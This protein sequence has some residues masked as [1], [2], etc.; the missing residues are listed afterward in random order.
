MSYKILLADSQPVVHLGVRSAFAQEADF[1]IVATV[2]KTDQIAQGV[3][4]FQPNLLITEARIDGVDVLKTLEPVMAQR[5]DMVV[6]VFS[7]T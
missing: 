5:T 6:I 1:E 7:D 4:D 3:E 2:T